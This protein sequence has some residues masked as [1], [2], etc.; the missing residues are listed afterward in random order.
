MACHSQGGGGFGEG[1]IKL[2]KFLRR[3]RLSKKCIGLLLLKAE[4]LTFLCHSF[5]K[6]NNDAISSSTPVESISSQEAA[7]LEDSNK[8]L[9]QR[10]NPRKNAIIAGVLVAGG[11]LLLAAIMIGGALIATNVGSGMYRNQIPLLCPKLKSR[12][13][14][15]LCVEK[16]YTLLCL[17]PLALH[18]EF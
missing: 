1:E 7:L 6:I 10:K 12:G 8:R 15:N 13:N 2:S 14:W 3:K 17:V 16:Y 5:V 18:L 4:G 9:D 11:A